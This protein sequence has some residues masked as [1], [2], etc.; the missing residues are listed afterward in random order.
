MRQLVVSKPQIITKFLS[1]EWITGCIGDTAEV[2]KVKTQILNAHSNTLRVLIQRIK[3]PYTLPFSHPWIVTACNAEPLQLLRGL[4]FTLNLG[5]TVML[6][7]YCTI[8]TMTLKCVPSILGNPYVFC[9]VLSS[10]F[11]L[12][13]W[14]DAFLKNILSIS[15][16]KN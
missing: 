4:Q 13:A 6:C 1:L 12:L 7:M 5:K 14:Q 16:W 11:G 3:S 10:Y 9:S 8:I 2:V 15:S